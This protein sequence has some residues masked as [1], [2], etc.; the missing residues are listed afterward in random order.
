LAQIR[1]ASL[2]CEHLQPSQGSGSD[3]EEMRL[4]TRDDFDL[5]GGGGIN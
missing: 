3:A 5:V 1:V 4:T 2:A